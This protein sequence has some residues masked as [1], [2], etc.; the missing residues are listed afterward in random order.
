MRRARCIDA[1]IQGARHDVVGV[2]G[3]HQLF[4]GKPHA[5]GRLAGEDVAEISGRHDE[6]Q[7]AAPSCAVAVK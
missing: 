2:G 1:V 3:D 6:G 7:A 4:D 5:L